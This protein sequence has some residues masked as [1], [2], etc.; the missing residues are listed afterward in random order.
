MVY[1]YT[2][3]YIV[4]MKPETLLLS[5]P[6]HTL[7]IVINIRNDH[8]SSICMSVSCTWLKKK[9]G[10]FWLESRRGFR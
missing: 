2:L 3:P 6:P 7:L 8:M 10:L 5:V 4:F 1:I 9:Y